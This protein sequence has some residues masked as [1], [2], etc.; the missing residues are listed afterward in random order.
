MPSGI[1]HVGSFAVSD[2]LAAD[3]RQ[4]LV[5]EADEDASDRQ[6]SRGQLGAKARQLRLQPRSFAIWAGPIVAG[7]PATAARARL[8]RR[9]RRTLFQYLMHQEVSGVL[10]HMLLDQGGLG[11]V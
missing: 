4:Q 5:M 6:Q 3:E 8:R 7:A 1:D 2:V 9:K 10:G 11:H